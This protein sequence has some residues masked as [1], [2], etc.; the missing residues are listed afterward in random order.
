MAAIDVNRICQPHL[1]SDLATP[2]TKVSRGNGDT[3][4]GGE[5]EPPF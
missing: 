4:T 3:N 5:N 1:V 2:P